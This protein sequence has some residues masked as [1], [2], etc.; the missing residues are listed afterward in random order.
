M[1]FGDVMVDRHAGPL[2]VSAPA[3]SARAYI[4][5][6]SPRGATLLAK[7]AAE[8]Y[9][10]RD[11]AFELVGRATGGRCHNSF[12]VPVSYDGNG[13]MTGKVGLGEYGEAT[14]TA[15]RHTYG[16]PGGVVRPVKNV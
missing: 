12:G 10:A 1:A 9:L 7:S 14:F 6:L 3:G 11:A 16:R 2:E 15:K 13:T 4:S 8:I 5:A